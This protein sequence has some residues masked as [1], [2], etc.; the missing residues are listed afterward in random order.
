MRVVC[1]I[2]PPEAIE[3]FM[4]WV[5]PRA[6]RPR[7]LHFQA[8]Q[9][10]NGVQIPCPCTHAVPNFPISFTRAPGWPAFRPE[11]QSLALVSR[12]G[13]RL[14]SDVRAVLSIRPWS[15]SPGIQT[16]LGSI[17][18]R[19]RRYSRRCIV[20]SSLLHLG[21]ALSSGAPPAAGGGMLYGRD[22]AA[23]ISHRNAFFLDIC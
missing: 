20:F 5:R 4:V 19:I 23:F 3:K 1:G 10:L 22:V 12:T 2:H 15:W 18:F 14:T 13:P 17:R 11:R 8:N 21:A 16:A 7:P 6:R 9:I